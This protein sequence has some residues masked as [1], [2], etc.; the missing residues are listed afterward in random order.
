MV[1]KPFRK[2]EKSE[3]LL[4]R[5]LGPYKIIRRTSDLNY[6][7][8]KVKSR[9]NVT[10]IV[11]VT[12]LKPFNPPAEFQSNTKPQEETR[13]RKEATRRPQNNN[14][15]IQPRDSNS[16]RPGRPRREIEVQPPAQQLITR[17][18][19]NRRQPQRFIQ[20]LFLMLLFVLVVSEPQISDGV[21]FHTNNQ[22][23][24]SNSEWV[25]T[26]DVT[27]ASIIENIQTL[28]AHLTSRAW[29][30]THLYSSS[31]DITYF[32]G[33]PS[34]R[35]LAYAQ[36][37]TMDSIATLNAIELRLTESTRVTNINLL[38]ENSKVRPTRGMV[39]LGG[40]ILKWLFGT[41]SNTDLVNLHNRLQTNAQT[42]E[43]IVHSIQDQATTVS[44][45][46]RRTE[47]NT[48][49][50][51]ELHETLEHLDEHF[52]NSSV[53]FTQSMNTMNLLNIAFL[54][55]RRHI[56]EIQFQVENI[57]LGLS[58]L[59]LERLP[60]ELFSP[61][62]LLHVLR[63]IAKTIPE[64]W[65]FVIPADPDN[66]WLLYQNIKVLTATTINDKSQKG[67]KL[68]LHIPIYEKNLRFDL[69]NVFNIP[70]FNANASHGLQFENLPEHVA[71]SSN[72]QK[73]VELTAQELAR[74]TDI[75]HQRICPIIKAFSRVQTTQSCVMS[76]FKNDA[77]KKRLCH[78]VLM[79]WKGF[80]SYYL[81]NGKW[82]YSDSQSR[83]V[84]YKCP[85][86]TQKTETITL[87]KLAILQ[88]P[89]GCTVHSSHWIFPPMF[90]SGSVANTTEFNSPKTVLL[91]NE[92]WMID[93]PLESINKE[94]NSRQ[95]LLN[96]VSEQLA[97]IKQG[98]EIHQLNGMNT[99]RL[100]HLSTMI[101]NGVSQ[102]FTP[103]T[104]ATWLWGITVISFC[105]HAFTIALG[106]IK[107]H[108][109][110]ARLTELNKRLSDHEIEMEETE[111]ESARETTALNI[112]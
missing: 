51:E 72:Q 4:H 46:L 69:Y 86:S 22:V 85:N 36:Q 33:N 112:N 6:E 27:F 9:N 94:E 47:L 98:N 7:V 12:N 11:H 62:H 105:M 88:I 54:R 48:K 30:E 2:I 52:F 89:R 93:E 31:N 108:Q 16:R 111:L 97:T 14:T 102:G 87:E 3:K 53:G 35:I 71:I 50:L 68:F 34:I 43:E 58:T 32:H 25:I 28:R 103:P 110:T 17:P 77:N 67:L 100:K 39:N 74:C 49:I 60:S 10:D 5:W 96:T 13:V 38:E 19:R 73:F 104:S 40:D 75:G 56:E 84:A 61:K 65:N 42:N 18:T 15:V 23:I 78:Q 20:A 79:P 44:E 37:A 99:L 57:A 90:K 83:V 45:N 55:V 70:T 1:Y 24:F 109:L 80:Y 66:V 91:E 82:I 81:G 41:V 26:T 95:R 76:L 101:R 8:Q 64:P 21:Y 59:S 29:N 107:I 92:L 63:E 106:I